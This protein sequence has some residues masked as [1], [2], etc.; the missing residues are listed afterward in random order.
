MRLLGCAMLSVSGVLCGI[1]SAGELRR[2]LREL[3]GFALLL[4]RLSMELSRFKTPLPELF[5]SLTGEL[6]GPASG[7]CRSIASGLS[8]GEE[9]SVLWRRA[10]ETLP[11]ALWEIFGPLGSVLGRYGAEEQ[12]AGILA[13][14][15]LLSKLR[16]EKRLALRDRMRVRLGVCS[17]GGFLLAVLLW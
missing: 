6:T 13:A 10:G 11:P 2:E 5:S 4:S 9:F 8:A 17:A 14:R 16:E 15:D 3:D 7:F 1:L 12:T